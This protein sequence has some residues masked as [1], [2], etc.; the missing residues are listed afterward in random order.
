MTVNFPAPYALEF[1][2]TYDGLTHKMLLPTNISGTPTPGDD[3]DE[4]TV[5]QN[6]GGFVTLDVAVEAWLVL[7]ANLFHQNTTFD[8]FTLWGYVGESFESFFVSAYTPVTTLTGVQ[9]TGDNKPTRYTMLTFRSREGGIAKHTFLEPFLAF[10]GRVGYGDADSNYQG[11]A[12][13]VLGNDGFFL[14]RDTSQLI[15]LNKLLGGQNEKLW[16]LRNR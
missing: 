2:Y 3:F 9:S 8:V 6:D 16:R 1:E 4:I 15:A 12:D 10:D 11:Y 13:F 5:E 7:L 14:A